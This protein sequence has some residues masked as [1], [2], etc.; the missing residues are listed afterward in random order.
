MFALLEI[1]FYVVDNV[2]SC[3]DNI[4]GEES[5]TLSV[6]AYAKHRHSSHVLIADLGFFQIDSII[7]YTKYT[8]STMSKLLCELFNTLHMDMV[9]KRIPYVP[10]MTPLIL[11][12]VD[13]ERSDECIDF[14]MIPSLKRKLNLVGTLGGQKLKIFEMNREKPPKKFREKRDFLRKTSLRQNRIFYFA[15]TQKLIDTIEIF[16]F[17]KYFFLNNDKN[18]FADQKIMKI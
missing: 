5:I 11:K 14:T 6:L 9:R 18:L 4:T 13:S 17:S 7:L 15:I 1:H 16:N 8:Y 2:K 10:Q 3:N 12:E